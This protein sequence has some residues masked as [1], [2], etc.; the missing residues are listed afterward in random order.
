MQI[1]ETPDEIID[2]RNQVHRLMEVSMEDFSNSHYD[3][4]P[5]NPIQVRA[6]P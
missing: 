5:V 6:R 1:G 3:A 4:E 2:R